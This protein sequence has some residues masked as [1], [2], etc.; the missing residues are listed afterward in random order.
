MGLTEPALFGGLVAV[1]VWLGYLNFRILQI[2]QDIHKLT[3]SLDSAT[4]EIHSLT[5]DMVGSLHEV[6]ANTSFELP[7]KPS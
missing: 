1:S 4:S 5:K 2:T 6:V 3:I 7:N